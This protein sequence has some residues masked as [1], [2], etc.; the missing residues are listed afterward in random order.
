MS[1]LYRVR[2]AIFSFRNFSKSTATFEREK[3]EYQWMLNATPSIIKLNDV[4]L[5]RTHA[6]HTGIL[7]IFI[8]IFLNRS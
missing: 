8:F 1:R 5:H 6:R 4:K 3:Y 7:H 2:G